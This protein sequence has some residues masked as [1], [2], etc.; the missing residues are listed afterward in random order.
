MARRQ[1]LSACPTAVCNAREWVPHACLPLPWGLGRGNIGVL[2]P[3][4]Y[5][6][7][8]GVS[9]VCDV[10][11]LKPTL[12][13]VVEPLRQDKLPLLHPSYT[14]IF[15]SGPSGLCRAQ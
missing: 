15:P 10:A 1:K 14:P 2:G 12:D 5:P 13:H 7:E 9:P 6:D 3:R 4:L 11:V 8:N